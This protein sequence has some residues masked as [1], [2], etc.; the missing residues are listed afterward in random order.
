MWPAKTP[1]W[2]RVFVLLTVG[3]GTVLAASGQS[4]NAP[5]PK[6]PPQQDEQEIDP[7]DVISVSTTEVLLPVTVRDHS[8]RLVTDLTRK[9]FRVF[10]NGIEQTLSDLSLRQVPVDVVLMIDA[11]S[12]AADN[13]DDF[14]GA[15]EGFAAHLDADDRI[16]LIQFDDRVALLQDWTRS[17]SQLQRALKRIAPGMFTRFH[18]AVLLAS[19]DQSARQ[20]ARHAVIVLT[21]GIDSGRGSTFDAAL[22]AALRSQTAIYVVSNTQIERAAKQQELSLLL[23][24][25]EA[26][27]RFNQLRID[28][29]RLGLAALDVSEQ[30]LEQLT[31]ATG[32]RLY[33]PASFR[34]LEKTYAE[35]ADELRHQYALY[36]AP[37]NAKKD[38]QFRRVRVETSNPT[39]Q[40]T[41]RIGYFSGKR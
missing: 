10:E 28:D 3:I 27:R 18:D 1:V 5:A 6:L 13:L 33:N 2:L 29:L 35:V 22:R 9:D 25:T 11:S 7:D 24:S 31:A 30:N 38:G 4:Q 34:D 41:A 20:T 36:Y 32:G 26:V 15:A 16:S 14:R 21:D 8:G 39:H 12:S 19:R 17:M 37:L 23:A 40:V